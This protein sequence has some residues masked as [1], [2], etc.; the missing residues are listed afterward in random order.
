MNGNHVSKQQDRS[1][2]SH[3]K[4]FEGY[5]RNHRVNNLWPFCQYQSIN[6]ATCS[7]V[8]KT[9]G[10]Q[11]FCFDQLALVGTKFIGTGQN[12]PK[13]KLPF[14]LW[15][16]RIMKRNFQEPVPRWFSCPLCLSMTVWS[17]WCG[18]LAPFGHLHL[19]LGLGTE[20][21]RRGVTCAEACSKERWSTPIVTEVQGS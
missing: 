13:R 18:S 8:V 1:K 9:Y 10:D 21:T 2:T 16:A 11:N 15:N 4:C 17:L 6:P 3:K 20:T 5:F 7:F 19:R 12:Q 14:V